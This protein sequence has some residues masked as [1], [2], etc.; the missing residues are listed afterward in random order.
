MSQPVVSQSPVSSPAGAPPIP[1]RRPRQV[2]TKR[3]KAA[4]IVRLLLKQGAKFSLDDLPEAL[5]IELTHEMGALRSIDK[6]TLDAVVAEFIQD[7]NDVGAAFPGGIENALE[8]LNG[9]L[10]PDA[11]RRLRL[12]TGVVVQGDPWKMIE[13][14]E[15][16]QLA[17]IL[18]KESIETSAVVL[19]KLPVPTSAAILGH[20]PGELARRITYA[21]STTGA[22]DPETVRTIG[23]AIATEIATAELKAFEEE[24]VSRV[25]AMLNFSRAETRD[26]VLDGLVEEDESFATQVRK[27]IFTFNDIETRI[28]PRDV[29]KITRAVDQQQLVI[30]IAAA[31]A[32]EKEQA[33]AEFILNSISKRMSEQ[34]RED[35]EDLG[36][37]KPEDGETAMAAVV[38]AIR[39]MEQ[40]GELTLIAPEG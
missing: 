2:L 7:V 1:A 13:G 30:A 38:G 19:A 37:V 28:T 9:A 11:L 3:Q 40:A 22:V 12:Q 21:V 32:S 39:D 31:L 34:I 26:R 18:Q 8:L 33:S 10:S 5:Q 27:A 14:L 23:H 15:V 4:V 25:G 35:A 17:E 24:P 6:D 29:P 36:R 20:L 16:P